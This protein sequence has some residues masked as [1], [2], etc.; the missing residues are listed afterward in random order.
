MLTAVD[1]A[2][3][4]AGLTPGMP[5]AD[6]RALEVL[7]SAGQ[8]LF[9]PTFWLHFIISIGGNVQCNARPGN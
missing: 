8:M 6:A 3:E 2:A 5:L 7:L 1:A 9:L 4:Q